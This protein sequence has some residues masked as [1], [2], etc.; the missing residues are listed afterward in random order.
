MTAVASAGALGS[1]GGSIDGAALRA[2]QVERVRAAVERYEA[3]SA[4]WTPVSEQPRLRF[5]LAVVWGEEGR[6]GA[7]RWL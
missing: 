3:E 2:T 4:R 7:F 5:G 6:C 1:G